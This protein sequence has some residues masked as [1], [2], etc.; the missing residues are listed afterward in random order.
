MPTCR[1]G[2]VLAGGRGNRQLWNDWSDEYQEIHGPQLDTRPLAWGLW[3]LPEA[4]VG[5]LGDIRD[6][7][8]L[9]L[10]C[11]GGQWS[12]FLAEAGAHPVGLDLSERQLAAAKRRMRSPYS[13]VHGDGEHLPFA[14]A[15][16]D[17]VL[18]DHGA[19]SWADPYQTIPE[20]TR[21]TKPGGRLVFNASTP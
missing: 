19:M 4:E 1:R 9:E 20:V 11:G 10:G 15:T 21:V 3:A 7:D 6:K 13:L 16:F 12:L 2:S 5:A 18:S 17:L 8:V 14:D